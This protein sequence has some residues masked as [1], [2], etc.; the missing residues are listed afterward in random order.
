MSDPPVGTPM[1]N[2]RSSTAQ[3][4]SAPI[5]THT[6]LM[7]AFALALAVLLSLGDIALAQMPGQPPGGMA[8]PDMTRRPRSRQADPPPAETTA[9]A[10]VRT[11]QV[12]QYFNSIRTLQARFVQNNPN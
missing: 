2:R 1:L 10:D 12:E 7:R 9:P 4:D 8:P 6:K 11:I 3:L 5:D